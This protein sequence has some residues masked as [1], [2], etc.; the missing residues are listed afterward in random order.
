MIDILRRAI[1][2]ETLSFAKRVDEQAFAVLNGENPMFVEHASRQIGIFFD[3]DKRLLDWSVEV[4]HWESLHSHN[5][6]AFIKK[7]K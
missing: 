6:V 4:E 1:P 7:I 5:A 3:K 2:T